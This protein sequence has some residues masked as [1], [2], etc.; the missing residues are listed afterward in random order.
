MKLNERSLASYATSAAPADNAGFLHK[1]GGRHAAFQRRWFV[2]RGNMLF[3]FEEPGSREPVGV[4]V[5]EG[6]TVELVE[7]AAD[8]AFALRFAGPRARTYVLAAESQA[9][10]EAWVKALSRASFH[11][12]RLVLREL[13]R[14]LAAAGG[15][16]PRPRAPAPR[17]NGRAAWSAE[18]RAEPPAAPPAAPAPPPRAPGPAAF[19]QLHERYGQEVRAL[20]RRGGRD[21]QP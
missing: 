20:R 9:A 15:P 6:C 21:P 3:Y 2:L 18:P 16:A 5:L 13:E 4:I 17:D 7:A 14:Q 8:F 10:L 11:Y 19:A 12:L 1:R